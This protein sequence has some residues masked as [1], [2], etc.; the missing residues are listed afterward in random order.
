MIIG[1][2]LDVVSLGEL[3]IDFT[4]NGVSEQGNQLFEANPGGAPCNVLSMLHNLGKKTS[5]IGK[6]GND[7]FG[8][9]LKR[10]LEEI[11]IGTDNL[12]MDNEI[13]TTLAFVHTAPDGERSFSFYRKPGADMMLN[14]SEI[15]E[16]IIKKARI[17]HFG[18]LSMTHEGVRKATQKALKIAKEN[19]LLI[20]FDPNLRPPLWESLD[21]AKDWIQYGLSQCDILKIADE[22]LQFVTG[23]KTIEEGVENLQR[24]YKIGLVLVTMGKFGSKAFFEGMS[25]E[26]EGIT[27][28]NTID[29]TGAGDTFCACILNYVL[30]HGLKAL[31]ESSLSDMLT[32]ANAAASIITTRRGAIRSMPAKEEILN[33]VF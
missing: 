17:F 29:T 11:G 1:K 14:E 30:D 12:V 28:K 23:C 6:V 8:L 18:T 5:F 32:F 31:T 3:L 9:L 4:V 13:N 2:E 22:E 24:N 7:Q 33:L 20:S 27:Q 19:N 15:R 21:E 10:T 26:K 16:D 25:V